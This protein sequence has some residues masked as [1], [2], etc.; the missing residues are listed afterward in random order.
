MSVDETKK[1]NSESIVRLR[2]VKYSR[3][4][5]NL[6]IKPENVMKVKR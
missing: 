3:L 6:A 5:L 1:L 4:L 2:E